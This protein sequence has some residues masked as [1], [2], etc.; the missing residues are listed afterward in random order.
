M[1]TDISVITGILMHFCRD[2]Q[3]AVYHDH[4]FE[5]L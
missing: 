2:E 3:I 5:I 4:S 1:V